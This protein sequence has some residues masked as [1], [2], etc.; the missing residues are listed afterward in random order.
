ML[1]LALELDVVAEEGTEKLNPALAGV[2]LAAGLGA[3]ATGLNENEGTVGAGAALDAGCAGAGADAAG[4]ENE[5]SLDEAA[6]GSECELAVAL[7]AL[8][9]NPVEGVAGFAAFAEAGLPK[10]KLGREMA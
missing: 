7:G 8:N 1:L 9:E 2:V 6:A 4:L 5:K 10:L 3:A